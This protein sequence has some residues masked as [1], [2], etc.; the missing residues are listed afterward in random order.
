MSKVLRL[1]QIP[2]LSW[3]DCRLLVE[4]VRDYAIFMLDADGFVATW[5]RGAEHI[6]GYRAEEI[7]GKH[8]SAFY[9]PEDVAAGKPKWEL[10]QAQ[11]EGRVEDEGWRVRKDGSLFWANVVITAL[12]DEDGRL[13]GYAKVTRDLSERRRA[14]QELRAAEERLRLLVEAVS[15]YAIYMLD[16]A[17]HV[18]TW[19]TG[20]ERLKG[21]TAHEIIGQHFSVFFT[22]AA[23]A[24]RKPERELEVALAEGHFADEGPRVRKDGS[25]FWASVVLTPIRSDGGQLLGFAKVTRDLSERRTVEESLRLSEE[26]LRLLV[27]AV[28]D[29]AI[30][31]LDPTGH[32]STWN[33]GAQR[34]KG[35]SA[36]EILGQHFSLFFTA[37]A[38]A[39]GKPERELESAR[40]FGRFEE[41]GVRV[42]KDGSEFWANVVITPV[43]DERGEVRGFAKVTRDLSERR[44]ADEAARRLLVEQAARSAAEVSEARL[45][46]VA[47]EAERANRIKDEFLAT[48][49]H[50]L[51]TP[52]NAI[53]G[54]A[55]LLRERTRGTP[56]ERGIEVIHRNAQAQA[57]II[58]DILDVSR[59]VTGKL[60]L[61][62]RAT[63][64]C[65]LVQDAL[66]VVRPAATAK[67]LRL[68]FERPVD[69]G[70]LVGDPVRLQ[71]VAWN[72]LSNAVKFTPAGGTVRAQV[73]REG[74][75]LVLAVTD[76]GRGIEPEFLPRLFDRFTQE[77]GST[78]RSFGGLGL[79]LSIVR[80]IIDLH[81]GHVA[82][83]SEGPGH[84][85]TFTVTL[86]IRATLPADP[87][88]QEPR[89]AE[90]PAQAQNQLTGVRVLI[91][92]DEQDARELLGEI[93]ERAGCTV[94]AVGSAREALE[95]LP[96]MR[97]HV[98]VSDI[99]MPEE[100]GYSLM[101][102]VRELDRARGGAIPAIALTAYTSPA[103]RTAAFQAG[104]STHLAKPVRTADLLAALH[105]LTLSVER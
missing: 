26:R 14:E 55:T 17:G 21:Y 62:M 38:R 95:R 74:S 39:D 63:D 9:P 50:E 69:A 40:S 84:G 43:R 10:Q 36:A 101:R 4:S 97:P 78:T 85:A 25:E 41:E 90:L 104:F 37:E 103:D 1:P 15:D 92:D 23:R 12:R 56:S 102:K 8:F 94:A 46:Q 81:G 34:L 77:D 33:T 31:M 76:D 58:D 28:E 44:M 66:D 72:L 65:S 54:W 99:G 88:A 60:H 80:H 96:Q 68:D 98:L 16:P 7:V 19:N 67:H 47:R 59:I 70:Q 30:Y 57:K 79:G 13:R 93:L 64:L 3:D 27:G 2:A 100:D 24:A 11:A 71:Q 75:S 52:L 22:P 6:K 89:D 61:D 20:A 45:R 5:S 42:R 49:S 35:Y 53:L 51:R 82:A 18:T 29:Y 87:P 32:I 105:T 48:V 83:S 73:W 91:V 86:P